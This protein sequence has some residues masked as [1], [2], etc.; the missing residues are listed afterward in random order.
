MAQGVELRTGDVVMF[1]TGVDRM[2]HG[3]APEV[4]EAWT[5]YEGPGLEAG[6]ETMAWLWNRHVAAIVS[7]NLSIEAWPFRSEE[8]FLHFRAIPL[9]GMV[10]GELFDLDGLAAD[11]AADGVYEC[12]FVAKPLMLRGGVGSPANAMAIK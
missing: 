3:E 10:F 2:L 8:E 12:L 1:R 11:C 4:D 5:E 9:L 6:D 7:D